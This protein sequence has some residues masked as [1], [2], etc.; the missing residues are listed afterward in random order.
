MVT[1]VV[2]LGALLLAV[3]ACGPLRGG[4]ESGGPGASGPGASGPGGPGGGPAAG[5]HEYA[6][7]VDG[8]RR[9]YRMHVPAPVAG[10]AGLPVVIFLHG[11]GGNAELFE[12]VSHMN[13]VADGAGFVVVYPNGSGRAV[14]KLLTWNAGD[15][16]GY[17]REQGVDDVAFVSSLLDTLTARFRT[18]PTRVYVTGFSNGAMMTYRLGC[19]LSGR[20]TAIA[21]VSGAMQTP[22]CQPSRPLP[23]LILHGTA[24][25]K[26]PYEGGPSTDVFPGAGTWVNRS[27]SYAVD[28]W[29]GHNGCPATPVRSRDGAVLRTGYSPCA[30]GTEVTLYT[31]EGGEHGWPGGVKARART[32]ESAPAKPDA[33]AV[34]WDFFARSPQLSG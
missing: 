19:E 20:I 11:G 32:D 29:T 28:F 22:T 16:C 26:V 24:D 2:T 23:V 34:I 27:V 1:A 6:L 25:P 30:E 8:R 4:A 12:Q 10:R 13:T 31:I 15:C 3:A 17:A 18:D 14:D 9:T 7:T 33:S 21:P 5:T